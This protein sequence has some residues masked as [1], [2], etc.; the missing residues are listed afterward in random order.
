MGDR[1]LT[2]HQTQYCK[3]TFTVQPISKEKRSKKSVALKKFGFPIFVTITKFDQEAA[4]ASGSAS[5]AGQAPPIEN[6]PV[7]ILNNCILL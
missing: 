7:S 2:L 3:P 5:A 4:T 1:A 6:E